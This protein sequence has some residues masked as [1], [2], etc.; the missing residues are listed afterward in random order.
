MGYGDLAD[1]GPLDLHLYLFMPESTRHFNQKATLRRLTRRFKNDNLPATN[2][3]HHSS[4]GFVAV[5]L[6][7]P[8]VLIDR[9]TIAAA[10]QDLAKRISQDYQ[11]KDL[12]LICILKGAF[13]FLSDLIRCLDIPAEI[14][15]VRLA[16]YGSEQTSSRNVK[17]TKDIE[18]PIKGKNVLIVEDIVDTGWTLAFLTERLSDF[19]PKSVKICAL[20]DKKE[21]R[22]TKINLQYIGFEIEDR[23]VVGYGL[24]VD[25]TYR[26]LPDICYVEEEPT[27]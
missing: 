14:D 19:N 8:K 6:S 3:Y 2:K 27:P 24:D 13:I 20:L 12:V 4:C 1:I 25:E 17:V 11:G 21:R 10:V 9:N 15:F 26:G 18:I 23:F 22:E 7:Q 5:A 16:S